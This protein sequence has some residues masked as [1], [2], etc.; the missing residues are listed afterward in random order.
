MGQSTTMTRE[1]ARQA[2]HGET[3]NEHWQR[4]MR[5]AHLGDTAARD[6]ARHGDRT[7]RRQPEGTSPLRRYERPINQSR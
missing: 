1:R 2:S 4:R 6:D 3:W 7:M 5:Q